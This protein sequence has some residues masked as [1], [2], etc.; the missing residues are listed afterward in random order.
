MCNVVSGYRLIFIKAYITIKVRSTMDKRI[1]LLNRLKMQLSGYVYTGHRSR[2]GWRGELPH[3]QFECPIHGMVE[4]YP[5]GYNQRLECPLCLA[6]A[7]ERSLPP[8][9]SAAASHPGP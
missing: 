4:N 2:D 6:E 5:S 9:T 7:M 8:A 3:Y 1:K